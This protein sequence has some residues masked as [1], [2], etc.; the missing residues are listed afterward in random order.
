MKIK[1][2]YEYLCWTGREVKDFESKVF[3]CRSS[4]PISGH[5]GTDS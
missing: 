3:V 5:L 2:L 1:R 4:E